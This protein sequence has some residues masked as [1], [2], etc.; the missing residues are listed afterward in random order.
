VSTAEDAAQLH[1]Y[2]AAGQFA[3]DDYLADTGTEEEPSDSHR[4]FDLYFA[5]EGPHAGVTDGV[6]VGGRDLSDRSDE[7]AEA[8]GATAIEE[9]FVA[10]YVD[11][12]L[13]GPRP[14][15]WMEDALDR[16]RPAQF[17]HLTY[18]TQL[19]DRTVREALVHG[20]EV[21]DESEVVF[22]Y[23]SAASTPEAFRERWDASNVRTYL[24]RYAETPATIETWER[25][26]RGEV[27]VPMRRLRELIE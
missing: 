23:V 4:G 26:G 19:G 8:S 17:V 9:R 27:T 6:V 10:E 18:G 2:A 7:N 11:R 1:G 5:G 3:I 16:S 22:R 21:L 25:T 13:D 15:T 20:V 24:E 14:R 12:V